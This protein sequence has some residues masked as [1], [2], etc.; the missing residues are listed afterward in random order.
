MTPPSRLKRF[1]YRNFSAYFRT[2]QRWQRR[3][4][5]A[6][7]FVQAA[8]V[9]SGV[10]GINTRQAV[11]YQITGF[12][13]ALLIMALV[14]GRRFDL[15][16]RIQ[17]Q[18]PRYATVDAPF[19][20]RLLIAQADA[21]PPG[22]NAA[23]TAPVRGIH[24]FEI[25][26]DPRPDFMQFSSAHEPG[27]E[28][29]N[30][31]DRTVGY[32]RW[33]WLV[34]LNTV[35]RIDEITV[36]PLAAGVTLTLTH[37][38]TPHA[39]GVLSLAAIALA[40]RDPFG[41]CRVYQELPL[42]GSVLVLPRIYRLP[43]LNL[44]GTL[45]TQPEH[46]VSIIHSG[47]GEEI[48]GLR[49][50]RPGD[51]LRDVHWKSFARTGTPMVK[52]YQAE[53]SERHALLLD[54]SGAPAGAAFEEAIALTASLVGDVGN[55]D[56]LLDLLFIEAECHCYT[57]GPGQLQAEALLRVLASVRA[58]PGTSLAALLAS[59][60]SRRAELSGC[61]CILLAWDQERQNMILRLQ[62]LG[63]PLLVW[64]VAE[65]K[66]EPCPDW[67]THLQPGKIEA[68]LAGL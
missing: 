20:Y 48:S 32:Y 7:K 4:T 28:R 44:P 65:Q 5:P 29:R 68:G 6:G 18:L 64:L 22:K 35:A 10:I 54:T 49:E 56:C 9:I 59:V 61:V 39:R 47:D 31:F 52:E 43:P 21:P 27:A 13:A 63:L 17:R 16:L 26:H 40:R 50:Y 33:A 23:E 36:P 24:L 38:C 12:L 46:H 15:R 19:S 37:T 66:P 51:A 8:L 14:S 11:A 41:L 30:W 3:F 58:C 67:I 45:H 53:Y 1:F 34:R 60:A 25:N 57:M 42:P 62:Q 2:K 55:N